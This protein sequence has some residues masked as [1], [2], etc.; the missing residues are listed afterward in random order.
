MHQLTLFQHPDAGQDPE[1]LCLLHDPIALAGSLPVSSYQS[2]LRFAVLSECTF[3]LPGYI[4]SQ[5]EQLADLLMHDLA[6]GKWSL[7]DRSAL[8]DRLRGMRLL[9]PAYKPGSVLLTDQCVPSLWSRLRSGLGMTPSGILQSFGLMALGLL[10][11]LWV[12]SRITS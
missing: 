3:L 2:Q 5:L 1:Q 4:P 8:R 11:C 6:T 9:P 7:T 12:L 10:A